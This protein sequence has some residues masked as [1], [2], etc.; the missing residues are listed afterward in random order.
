MTAP[1]DCRSEPRAGLILVYGFS[2][3]II[4]AATEKTAMYK[5]FVPSRHSMVTTVNTP[6]LDHSGCLYIQDYSSTFRSHSHR[7]HCW[8]TRTAAGSH[9]RMYQQDTLHAERA[10][11]WYL[12][13]LKHFKS[14]LTESQSVYVTQAQS[15]TGDAQLWSQL[16]PMKPV[17]QAH[18][19]VMWSQSAPF[20]QR[21]TSEQSLP[22]KPE[23]QPGTDSFTSKN[24]LADE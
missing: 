5:V 23:G 17:R 18:W 10:S 21:Q 16:L 9:N 7:W 14:D 15:P 3:S 11:L 22:W 6:Y 4:K 19:P 12:S 8:G 13:E 24:R 1:A 2:S 20:W